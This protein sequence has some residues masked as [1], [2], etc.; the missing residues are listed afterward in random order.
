MTIE[1]L[2]DVTVETGGNLIVTD[3]VGIGTASPGVLLN[4]SGEDT[5]ILR[6]ENSDTSLTTDQLIGEVQFYAN[7][8]SSFGTGPKSWIKGINTSA[9]GTISALTF[10]T[11]FS[12]EATGIERMR[13]AGNGNVGIGTDDPQRIFN[14]ESNV[15]VIRLS[16][17]NATDLVETTGF[18]EFYQGNNTAQAGFLGFPS[19]ID[20]DIYIRNNTSSGVIRFDTNGANERMRIDSSGN[21]G[22]G[23]DSPQNLLDVRGAAGVPGTLYLGTDE[24]T[25]VDADRLG[26]IYFNAP[27]ESSGTDAILPGAVIRAEAETTFA[28][29]NNQTSL[30]FGTASSGTA[31]EKVRIDSFGNTNFNY[32]GA[33]SGT[34]PIGQLVVGNGTI[35][36]AHTDNTTILGSKD[37]VAGGACLSI[38]QESGVTTEVVAGDT[39]ARIWINGLEYKMILNSV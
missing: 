14:I 38:Y 34:Q 4:L 7:D 18:I 28:A 37:S 24:L 21:V 10:G 27:L 6:L 22:I 36:D 15:P 1:N 26:Q 33:L 12:T 3:N 16:D 29:D 31:V 17:N 25:V 8:G 35:P 19:S 39:T 2:G 9:G 5:A 11:A 23:T 32:I 13:I 30:I 20:S